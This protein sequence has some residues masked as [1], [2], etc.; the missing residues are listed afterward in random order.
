MK[1]SK[2]K[3]SRRGAKTCPCIL[4]TMGA[5]Q[6]TK[7]TMATT[8]MLA[9]R[10]STSSK[11]SVTR[12]SIE[13]EALTTWIWWLISNRAVLLIWHPE[14]KEIQ[15]GRTR[16]RSSHHRTR[17]CI[18]ISTHKQM[19]SSNRVTKCPLSDWIS[20]KRSPISFKKA[21]PTE[22]TTH[23][24]MNMTSSRTSKRMITSS[25]P[26]MMTTSCTRIS[27]TS[28]HPRPSIK[29]RHFLSHQLHSQGLIHTF[30]IIT[31]EYRMNKAS[32]NKR[33]D[34]QAGCFREANPAQNHLAAAQP[35]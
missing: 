33:N 25:T 17:D 22:S 8:V 20:S 21:L 5:K 9:L 26:V 15:K 7:M 4:V 13:L 31:Y 11:C 35:I 23:R 2:R 6:A 1:S 14:I 3:T 27:A 12:N 16:H 24:R 19:P 32:E 30:Q 10:T 18:S 28:S 29:I 34:G